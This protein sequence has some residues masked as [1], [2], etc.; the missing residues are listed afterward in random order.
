MDEKR[1]AIFKVLANRFHKGSLTELVP[2]LPESMREQLIHEG[3][4]YDNVEALFHSKDETIRN[5]HYSWMVDIVSQW[6]EGRQALIVSSLPKKQAMGLSRILNISATSPR[7][8]NPV[9]HFFL[10]QLSRNLSLGHVL[11]IPLIPESPLKR[12]LSLSKEEIEKIIDFLGVYDLANEMKQIINKKIL[13]SILQSIGPERKKILKRAMLQQDKFI[14][15]R[16]GVEH[17]GGDQNAMDKV[18]HKR[19]MIRLAKGISGCHPDLFWHLSHILDTGRAKFLEKYWEK[20]PTPVITD[21]IAR[22]IHSV[23]KFLEEQ[24]G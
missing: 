12:L 9:K 19:G 7:L 24:S 22:Q 14:Q 13:A 1:S 17:F 6:D 3:I 18:L 4:S 2:L 20:D 15:D 11:P 21:S 23:I 10:D 8:S 5:M 16:M